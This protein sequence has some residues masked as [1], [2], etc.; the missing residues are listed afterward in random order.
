MML[1]RTDSICTNCFNTKETKVFELS[2]CQ[3]DDDTRLCLCIS[4]LEFLESMIG[5]LKLP[6]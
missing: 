3:Y 4:C 1:I 6:Y 2:L 5:D